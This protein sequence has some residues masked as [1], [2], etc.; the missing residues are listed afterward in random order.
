[1]IPNFLSN[2][3]FR[4]SLQKPCIADKHFLYAP[5][6]GFLLL[7]LIR[8]ILC[9]PLLIKSYPF[10]K[11][12]IKCHDLLENFADIS[13]YICYSPSF[14]LLQC[15]VHLSVVAFLISCLIIS[16]AQLSSPQPTLG[17]P[18]EQNCILLIDCIAH[19]TKQSVFVKQQYWV[20]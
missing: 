16:L 18:E 5:Y 11:A 12:H 3:I 13:S 19:R 14:K 4:H 15:F 7:L 8:L 6:Q 10:S 9:V 17:E 1:M 2:L 20:N